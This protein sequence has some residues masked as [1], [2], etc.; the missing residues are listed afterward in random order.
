MDE[1]AWWYV[2]GNWVHPHEASISIND[3]GVLRGY[4]VFESL[5]TYHRRPFHLD[6]HLQRL[7]RSAQ[8]IELD[9]TF[10]FDVLRN[11]VLESI[12]RNAYEHATVRLLVTGGISEDGVLPASQSSLAVMVTQLAER[13]MERFARGCKLI[14]THLTRM[15]PEAKT[16]NYVSAIR[17]L[18]EAAQQQASDALFVNEQGHVLECTRSNFFVFRG[19]TLITPQAEVLIGVTRNVV[20]ALARERFA[21]EERPILLHELSSIDEAFITS[22]S[23]EIMPVV[24]INDI[25]IGDG[26]PGVRTYELEQHFIELVEQGTFK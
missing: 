23:K 26:K 21:V 9:V 1:Q 17:A 13:D 22:S 25:V 8:L 19:D 10:S 6:E 2:N 18:K 24:Q 5:R 20:L 3:V 4:S 16:S 15:M 14:T 7:Y 11:I 12:Q